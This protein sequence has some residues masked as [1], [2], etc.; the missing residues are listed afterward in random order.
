MELYISMFYLLLLWHHN[1]FLYVY[2]L[3]AEQTLRISPS[4]PVLTSV[5]LILDIDLANSGPNGKNGNRSPS[6]RS[7]MERVSGSF[8]RNWS[9]SRTPRPNLKLL[10]YEVSNWPSLPRSSVTRVAAL[11]LRGH[12]DW[13]WG[14]KFGLMVGSGLPV[15]L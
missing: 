1:S 5:R 8:H 13:I 4:K 11:P 10:R 6:N 15:F 14:T 12:W 3:I 9:D 7:T 2:Q